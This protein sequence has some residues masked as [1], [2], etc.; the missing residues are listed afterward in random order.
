MDIKPENVLVGFKGNE[1]MVKLCD[2]GLSSLMTAASSILTEFCGSPGFF[3]PEV[4]MQKRFCGYKA[5]IFSLGCIALEMMVPQ[6]F[7]KEVWVSVYDFLKKGEVTAFARA[8]K[9][10]VDYSH[11]EIK[12]GY[13]YFHISCLC[14]HCV[15]S[16]L[17]R[18]DTANLFVSL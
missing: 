16:M 10:A 1:L 13:H 9:E 17:C 2:F 18:N 4:Y 7:F 15:C 6:V 8:M 14:F 5:D 12:V 3:A 11:A